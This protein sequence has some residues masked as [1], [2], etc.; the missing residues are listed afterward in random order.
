M[1]KR[2]IVTGASRGIGRAIAEVLALKQYDLDLIVSSEASAEELQRAD[3][4]KDSRANV[5]AV[6]LASG[7][8]I[9]QF[10]ANW[11]AALDK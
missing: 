3:F 6:D 11:R 10:V 5:F 9:G 2:V 8:A 4:V 7:D 1:R